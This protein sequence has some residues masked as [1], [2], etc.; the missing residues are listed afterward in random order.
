MRV[1]RTEGDAVV[2]DVVGCSASGLEV[3]PDDGSGGL[4]PFID[5]VIPLAGVASVEVSGGF[6]KPVVRP[7]AIGAATVGA[8]F[9]GFAYLT[10]EDGGTCATGYCVR[11]SRKRKTVGSLIAGMLS[12]AGGGLVH[13]L[14]R[15][16]EIWY[17]WAE[18]GRG[19]AIL[20][21]RPELGSDGRLGASLGIRF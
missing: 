10:G 8:I 9:G 4:S 5:H 17:P 21:L 2:G 19:A 11:L 18:G 1:H 13:G 14:S 7:V 12:G 20:D 6:K 3:R 15:E 16:V